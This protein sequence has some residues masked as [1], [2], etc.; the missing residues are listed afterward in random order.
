M[1]RFDALAAVTTA[2]RD[3]LRAAAATENETTGV[4]AVAPGGL[5][6]VLSPGQ[7][8]VGIWLHRVT[9]CA[10]RRRVPAPPDPAALDRSLPGV[11]LDLHYLL[12]ARAQEVTAQHRLLGWAVRTLEDHPQLPASV[13]NA[14]AFAG[15]FRDDEAVELVLEPLTA[16]EENDVWQV[17]QSA[18]QPA[19]AYVAR[20]VVLDSRRR[21]P[22]AR[23]VEER[24]LTVE[25][26]A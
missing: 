22:D 24:D 8:Q 3:L 6:S 2:V 10:Q 17:A 5:G 19:L 11:A 16:Q 9:P 14:G 23:A 25:A 1:A 26:I 20:M 4:E 13:L 21:L 15:C 18:R 7:R 12:V